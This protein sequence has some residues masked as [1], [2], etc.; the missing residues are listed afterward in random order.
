MLLTDQPFMESDKFLETPT[1][2]VSQLASEA[3]FFGSEKVA[4]NCAKPGEPSGTA[5]WVVVEFPVRAIAKAV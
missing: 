1:A 5:N 2:L 4:L 3:A